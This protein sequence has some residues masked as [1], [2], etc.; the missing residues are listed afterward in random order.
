MYDVRSNNLESSV[1][2]YQPRLEPGF[3]K[4]VALVG[5]SAILAATSFMYGCNKNNKDIC[6][7]KP[8]GIEN[9]DLTRNEKEFLAE[10]NAH[11]R[12]YLFQS[13]QS[14]DIEDYYIK[15]GWNTKKLTDA[16]VIQI[17]RDI[18]DFAASIRS[19]K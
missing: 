12:P 3:G 4:K 2:T 8:T 14:K 6:P 10:Y 9:L 7:T 18:N 15:K 17:L 11:G 13:K 1:S 5:L 19:I 16:Q